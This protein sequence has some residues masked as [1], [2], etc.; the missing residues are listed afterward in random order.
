MSEP[1][2]RSDLAELER[3]LS[4]LVEAGVEPRAV[5]NYLPR[6]SNAAAALSARDYLHRLRSQHLSEIERLDGEIRRVDWWLKVTGATADAPDE[7]DP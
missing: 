4:E 5:L 7:V 2:D 3:Q 1:I 6:F